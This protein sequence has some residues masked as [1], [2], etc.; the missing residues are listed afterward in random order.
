M[1][2]DYKFYIGR[3]VIWPIF[4]I[5]NVVFRRIFTFFSGFL[6]C[7]LLLLGGPWLLV[8][9]VSGFLLRLCGEGV[10]DHGSVGVLAVLHGLVQVDT[11]NVRDSVQDML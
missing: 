7:W 2:Q 8:C 9:F 11:P 3:N 5:G 6:A 4:P 1:L 10:R